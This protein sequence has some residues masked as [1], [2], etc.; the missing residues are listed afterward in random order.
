MHAFPRAC[1]PR[2][3]RQA[4]L[5]LILV[6]CLF[7]PLDKGQAF[8]PG[9]DHLLYMVIQKIRQP[10]GMVAFQSRSILS[11]LRKPA[12]APGDEAEP[13]VQQ[14][15]VLDEKLTYSSGFRLRSEFSFPGVSGFQV[16]SESG[17][18]RV[19][20]GRSVAL[21][22]SFLDYYTDVLLFRDYEELERKMAMDGVDTSR[23][24]F[25]RY[26]GK[27]CFVIGS[28]SE[29]GRPFPGLWVERQSLFPVRY[30]LVKKGW[31]LEFSYENWQQVSRT[32]YPMKTDIHMDG[33]LMAQVRVNRVAL[34]P[35][36]PL[37]LFQVQRIRDQYPTSSPGEPDK[38]HDLD[39]QLEEFK[40]I[41]E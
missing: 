37:G 8:A 31:V 33:Q 28:P 38:L 17:F 18:V 40:K 29:P 10:A 23:V 26:R 12:T 25:R 4:A 14:A 30:V 27:V 15:L 1:L 11:P 34:E 16:E 35:N 39:R 19:E 32:W 13:P 5:C 41:Y 3:I 2:F 24:A 22:K 20:N 7:L 21:E 6:I 36:V 9:A